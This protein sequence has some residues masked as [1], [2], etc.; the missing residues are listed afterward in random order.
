MITELKRLWKQ[1]FGDTDAFIDDFF[2]IAYAPERCRYLT[3][4][5]HVAAALYW[6]DCS[7]EDQKWAYL[8][9]IA[10]DEAHRNQ[11]LCRQLM[12]QIHEHLQKSGY[13]GSILVPGN[14]ELFAFYE[15]LGYRTCCSVAEQEY[16]ARVAAKMRS[17]AA[18][19]Y[20]ALRR[21]L[22]P[23]GGAVQEGVTLEFLGHFARFYAGD[24]FV[25]AAS[26]EEGRAIVHELLGSIDGGAVTAALGVVSARIR[27]P[28]ESKP[29]AMYYPLEDTPAPAY[30]GLALD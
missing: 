9:A 30:F 13:A 3:V 14:R 21:S 6:F 2:R 17:V 4:D 11:G 28:G 8:Y 15:K 12:S 5:G 10:T 19:E 27:T 23:K 16:S 26:S 7:V 20:A 25:L 1:A 24:G 29:F 18:S 22:L